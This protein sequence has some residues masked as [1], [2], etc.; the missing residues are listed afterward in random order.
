MQY[1]KAAMAA[2]YLNGPY[3]VVTDLQLGAQ[4]EFL[5]MQGSGNFQNLG[6]QF[7]NTGVAT[8]QMQIDS[9]YPLGATLIMPQGTFAGLCWNEGLNRAGVDAGENSVGYLGTTPDPLGSGA[10]A[11]ISIY[12]ARADTST[13]TTGGSTQDITDQWEIALTMGYVIP[14]LSVTGDSVVME[15]GQAS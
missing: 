8:T 7:A 9:A 3:D 10:I 6:F 1:A 5:E 13:N 2:R 12:T 4:F 11:D 15:V 14:P